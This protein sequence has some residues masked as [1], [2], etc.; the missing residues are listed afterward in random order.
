AAFPAV[1]DE[2]PRPGNRKTTVIGAA[3]GGEVGA[4]RSFRDRVGRIEGLANTRRFADDEPLRSGWPRRD[5]Q[6]ATGRSGG[7]PVRIAEAA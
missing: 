2:M 1:T 7:V 4:Q 6:A 5:R 3:V